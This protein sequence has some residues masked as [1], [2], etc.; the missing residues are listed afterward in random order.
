MH[1]KRLAI[2]GTSQG[3]K[4]LYIKAKQKGLYTIAFSY[5]RGCIP[6]ELMDEYYEIS[7]IEKDAIVALCREIGVDGVVSNGSEL[8]ANIA[9]YVAEQLGLECTPYSVISRLQDKSKVRNLTKHVVG[10]QPIRSYIFSNES[11]EPLFMPCV[12]KPLEGSGKSGVSFADSLQAF[13]EAIAY[14]LK[15]SDKAPLIEEYAEGN[16]VSVESI[17]FQGKHHV[18]QITDKDSSGAPH[19]V[20]LGHHQPSQLS[21][22][23]QNKI[24]DVLPR[25]LDAVGYVSGASHTELKVAADGRIFLIEINPRGGGDEISN[26]LV[27]LSTGY[28]YIGAM[29]DVATGDFKEPVFGNNKC[30]GILFLTRQT[31]HLLPLFEGAQAQ[32]WYIDSHIESLD[33]KECTGNA[34]KNGFI[35]YQSEKR[36]IQ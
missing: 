1:P 13:R 5:N 4:Q 18:I 28:D 15:S 31:Q 29:I 16:E 20:E 12:V 8:T 2:I 19:F 10:L 36:I 26:R 27:Y 11:A 23:I 34:S 9:S 25:I 33:L 14:S 22:E 7:I 30:A 17:S 24:C 32:P 21:A 35:I 6:T 3:Q